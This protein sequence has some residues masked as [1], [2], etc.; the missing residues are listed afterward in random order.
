MMKWIKGIMEKMW[1]GH[2][3]PFFACEKVL[4]ALDAQ[5]AR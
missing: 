3:A 2:T 5:R 1:A 4:I